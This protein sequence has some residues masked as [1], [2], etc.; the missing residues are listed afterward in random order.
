MNPII[1]LYQNMDLQPWQQ[2]ST[3]WLYSVLLFLI[4]RNFSLPISDVTELGSRT[5]LWLTPLP[6]EM[7][8]K[9]YQQNSA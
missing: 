2:P 1:A 4:R 8:S 5:S 9:T 6:S 3:G 7:L